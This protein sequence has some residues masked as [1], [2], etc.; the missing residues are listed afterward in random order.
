MLDIVSGIGIS[1]GIFNK[2]VLTLIVHVHLYIFNLRLTKN[3]NDLIRYIA[4]SKLV[5]LM[6]IIMI[7]IQVNSN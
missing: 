6:H 3:K 4:A 2:N 1:I 5:T 7:Y